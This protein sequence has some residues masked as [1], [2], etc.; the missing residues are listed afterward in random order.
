[1]QNTECRIQNSGVGGRRITRAELEF[2][3]A[4]LEILETPPLPASRWILRAIMLCFSFAFA[5]ACV[6][7]IEIVSVARGKIVPGGRVKVIQP[8]QSGMVRNIFVSE[9][10][11]VERGQ[12]LIQLDATLAGA[13]REQVR[14]QQITLE[15]E[16]AVLSTLLDWTWK[17][18]SGNEV[19]GS[20]PGARGLR[21]PDTELRSRL[22]KEA[23]P[24]QVELAGQKLSAR[25]REYTARI[26]ALREEGRERIAEREVVRARIEQLDSTIPLI[27]ERAGSLRELLGRKMAARVQWLEVEQARIEAVKERDLQQNTLRM[28]DA[29]VA[30]AAQQRAAQAAELQSGLLAELAETE[31]R[32]TNLNQERI[33]AESR[34]EAQTLIAPVAGRVHQLAV[35]TIGGVVA[36]AQELMRI[37]PRND[38]IE[39]EA[40]IPNKD[41][42]FVHEGQA[43][44]IKVDTFAFTRYG[45]IDGEVSTLSNDAIADENLGLV[46]AAR[47]RMAKAAMRVQDKLIDLVPGMAVTVEINLGKRRLIEYLLGP[48]LKYKDESL[49]EP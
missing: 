2:L 24:A 48:L 25:F 36:P 27:T 42:G 11:D 37:V 14:E 31:S 18:Q 16:H 33:K 30:S 23:W 15:V 21:L 22:P 34:V 5:W 32:I 13:E 40:W 28:Q 20:T 3:P 47:I 6:G 12:A 1:M 4:A 29:A 9:G 49:R 8:L 35:H 38:A 45:T 7:E 39:A 46:Y 17:S 26:E 19:A 44:E 41:I 43:A 10:E